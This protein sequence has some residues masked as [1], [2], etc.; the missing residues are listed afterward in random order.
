MKKIQ[1][2]LSDEE[3]KKLKYIV[4]NKGISISKYVKDCVLPEEQTFEDIWMEFEIRLKE[5][6]KNAEFT[7]QN[8]MT[9]K[10]WKSFSR[11]TKLSIARLFNKKVK[12]DEVMGVVSLGHSSSNVSVYKKIAD[13]EF[14]KQ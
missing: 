7:V 14:I 5:Y 4:D 6:P 12:N 10:R 3:Y 8:I 9:Y 1:F 11:S 13:V 2:V